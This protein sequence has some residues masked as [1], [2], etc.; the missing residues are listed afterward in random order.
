V[1]SASGKFRD[2]PGKDEM[3]NKLGWDASTMFWV[4]VVEVAIAVLF[5]IPRT[6]LFGAILITAYLGGATAAHVRI[7]DHANS[8][9]PIIFGVVTWVALGL[10]DARVFSLA[11]SVPPNETKVTT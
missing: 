8:L 4:G 1:V 6:S 7:H 10:R 11:F 5:L 3:F 9:F 2:F